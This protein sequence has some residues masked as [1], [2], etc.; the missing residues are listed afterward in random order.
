MIRYN[1]ALARVTDTKSAEW[2]LANLGALGWGICKH[3]GADHER[4]S[5]PPGR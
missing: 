3:V 4:R 2:A 1:D 5:G